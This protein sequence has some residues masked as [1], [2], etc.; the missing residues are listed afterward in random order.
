L[1]WKERKALDE[2]R[3]FIVDWER[4]EGSLAELCRRYEISR[5]TGTLPWDSRKAYLDREC[6][7]DA[8]L[9]REVDALLSQRTMNDSSS[10]SRN[11]GATLTMLARD[12]P[13]AIVR[14]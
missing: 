9:R 7:G 13:V 11:P 14:C 4:E 5:Q 2:K 10:E 3:S 1:P 6:G 12:Q 8:D